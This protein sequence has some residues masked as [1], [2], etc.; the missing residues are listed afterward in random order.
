M[1]GSG[2]IGRRKSRGSPS[3][4]TPCSCIVGAPHSSSRT[5]VTSLARILT[6]VSQNVVD[7]SHPF[8]AAV[9]AVAVVTFFGCRRLGETVVAGKFSTL[10]NVTRAKASVRFREMRGGVKSVAFDI[11]WTKTTKQNGATI[12]VTERIDDLASS[13]GICPIQAL[14]NHLRVNDDSSIPGGASLFAYKCGSSWKHMSRSDFLDFTKSVWEAAGLQYVSGHSFRIGGAV[15][16]LLAGVPP[17]IVAST[18][19]WTSLAFLIYW[20]RVEEI[21]PLST[22][23]AYK[24]AQLQQLAESFESFRIRNNLPSY[25]SPVDASSV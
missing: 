1:G 17:E 6:H 16:L 7:L 5:F 13:H 14:R 2:A 15:A 4:E 3:E 8:Q 9:W 24:Q 19:G 18:G 10:T 23:K 21:L 20:R 22:S 25:L 11:P 12:I